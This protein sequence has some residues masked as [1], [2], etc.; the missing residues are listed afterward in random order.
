MHEYVVAI[1]FGT[2]NCS[3]N[4]C[5]DYYHGIPHVKLS[6]QHLIRVYFQTHTFLAL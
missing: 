3:T 2:D 6:F 1:I 4:G 5:V